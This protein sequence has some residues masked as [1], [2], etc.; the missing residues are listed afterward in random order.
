MEAIRKNKEN[1]LYIIKDIADKKNITNHEI[2]KNTGVSEAALSKIMR[3][4]VINPRKNVIDAIYNYLTTYY[5]HNEATYN[6]QDKFAMERHEKLKKVK[7]LIKKYNVTAYEISKNTHLT[8]VG[9]QKIINGQSEKPLSV[10]LDTIYNYLTTHYPHNET[11]HNI[12]SNGNNNAPPQQDSQ[13]QTQE[14]NIYSEMIAT[15]REL[16]DTLKEQNSQYRKEIEYLRQKIKGYVEK[17]KK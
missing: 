10:T 14:N 16:I 11:T 8:A 2:S 5:P 15:Q 13:V 1:M 9:V 12:N 6:I 17:S 7:D 4:I 3:G